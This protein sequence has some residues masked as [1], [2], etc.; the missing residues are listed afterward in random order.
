MMIK[1]KQWTGCSGS[2]PVIVAGYEWQKSIGRSKSTPSQKAYKESITPVGARAA[3]FPAGHDLYLRFC[4][5]PPGYVL[6]EIT[7]GYHRLKVLRVDFTSEFSL[8]RHHQIY[9]TQ[10]I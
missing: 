9:K 6:I 8:D 1:I 3:S 4:L 5:Q 2:E 10:P 7:Q